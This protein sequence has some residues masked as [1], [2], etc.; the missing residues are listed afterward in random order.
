[1]DEFFVFAE[2]PN[3]RTEEYD[4]SI[5]WT[6]FDNEVYVNWLAA[7]RNITRISYKSLGFDKGLMFPDTIFDPRVWSAIVK[8]IPTLWCSLRTFYNLRGKAEM[9]P[10]LDSTKFKP[11]PEYEEV[12]NNMYIAYHID[13][14]S[15]VE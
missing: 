4:A 9:T 5:S 8:E 6:L 13:R 2:F 7:F 15:Q 12:E 1:M 3:E 10:F 11:N 14:V